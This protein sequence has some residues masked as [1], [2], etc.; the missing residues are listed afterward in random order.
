MNLMVIWEGY[1]Y[2]NETFSEFPSEIF[3]RAQ[4]EYDGKTKESER[5]FNLK[6]AG[7]SIY[8]V[9]N[10]QD[11]MIKMFWVTQGI[12]MVSKSVQSGETSSSDEDQGGIFE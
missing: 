7:Q 6:V 3:S 8:Y 11:N 10:E 5:R 9:L 12:S 2:L 4:L 1:P